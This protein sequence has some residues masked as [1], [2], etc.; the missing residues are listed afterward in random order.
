MK[1]NIA[2]PPWLSPG[3]TMTPEQYKRIKD[4]ASNWVKMFKNKHL[5]NERDC[6][7]AICIEMEGKKRPEMIARLK[8]WYNMRRHEREV[9]ELWA[10]KQP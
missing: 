8:F 7:N 3:K 5:I 1:I 10:C 2:T 4:L 6:L 9:Q